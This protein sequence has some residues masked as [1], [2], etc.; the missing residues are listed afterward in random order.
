MQL[1]GLMIHETTA[2]ITNYL[3][4]FGTTQLEKLLKPPAYSSK[5]IF[6]LLPAYEIRAV[7]D[8]GCYWIFNSFIN[9]KTNK[10]LHRSV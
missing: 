9:R 7:N 8:Y 1:A 10:L 4:S 3:V 5:R 2:F 6:F